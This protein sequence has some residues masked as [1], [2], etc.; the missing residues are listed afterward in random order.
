[1]RT[2]QNRRIQIN[3][4]YYVRLNKILSHLNEQQITNEHTCILHYK[5][6]VKQSKKTKTEKAEKNTSFA[7]SISY[8][9]PT[10][11]DCMDEFWLANSAVHRHHS[12][13]PHRMDL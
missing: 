10:E 6:K 13:E 12:I 11:C 2:E 1:M 4:N 5:A 9:M 7:T 8:A 3:K